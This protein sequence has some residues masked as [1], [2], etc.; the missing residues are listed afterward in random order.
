MFNTVSGPVESAARRR[1]AFFLLS[2]G[3][4]VLVF[5]S[6]LGAS[7]WSVGESPEPPIPI[8]FFP[9]PS[10]IAPPRGTPNGGDQPRRSEQE[11]RKTELQAPARI[12]TSHPVLEAPPSLPLS[13]IGD[14]PIDENF[15]GSTGLTGDPN[16]VE[17]GTGNTPVQNPGS[18][19]V[20]PA[21][22]GVVRPVLV[23]QVRPDYPEAARALRQQG[24]LVVTAVID[25]D[26][27]VQELR[28]VHSSSPLF[29]EPALQ[30]IRQW[31]YRPGTLSGRAVRV[32]LT[33]EIGF[34]LR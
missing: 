5:G 12:A 30:A 14:S 20:T 4:H 18:G 27:S 9:G 1:I 26:G 33:V 29:E 15:G 8:V 6:L 17:G 28:V 2:L 25:T 7:L 22:P 24:V 21:T 16:G 11:R 19:L 31:R 13:T 34:S 32:L 23:R 3:T 10:A